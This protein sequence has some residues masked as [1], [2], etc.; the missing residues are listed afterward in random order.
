[1]TSFTY[2]LME[3]R[4]LKIA[5]FHGFGTNSTFMEMQ[6][7]HVNKL[8][9]TYA[10]CVYINGPYKANP[11]IVEEAIT[12]VTEN[13]T[14]YSWFEY[15]SHTE[16]E[17][18]DAAI[19]NASKI[20]DAHGPFDGMIGF[21]QGGAMAHFIVMAKSKGLLKHRYLDNIKFAIFIGS[22]WWRFREIEPSMSM[23]DFPTLHIVSKSDFALRNASN[24][25]VRYL[26]PILMHHGEGHKIPRLSQ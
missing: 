26:N 2:K 24:A 13:A 20:L 14:L 22:V 19:S 9:S 15:K 17:V 10:D 1:M 3:R 7:R 11:H 23:I 18:F 21:S 8:L 25:T 6:M 16:R 5:C 12:N 4:K